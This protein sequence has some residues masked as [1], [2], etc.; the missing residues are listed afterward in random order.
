M[1]VG[2]NN[3]YYRAFAIFLYHERIEKK[4]ERAIHEV[5]SNKLNNLKIEK[6]KKQ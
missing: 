5:R 4:M 1:H 3:D 6:T 2:S